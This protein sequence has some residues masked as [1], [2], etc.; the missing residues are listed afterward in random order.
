VIRGAHGRFQKL[1]NDFARHIVRAQLRN[2][3]T[4]VNR[5]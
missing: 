5:F 1:F 2:A 3:A 4:R